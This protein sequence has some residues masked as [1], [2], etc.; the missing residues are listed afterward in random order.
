MSNWTDAARVTGFIKPAERGDWKIEAFDIT[1]ND[2]IGNLGS[3]YATGRGS[4]A[5]GKYTKLTHKGRLWMSDTSD[6]IRDL[7]PL[8]MNATGRVLI[9]GLGLGCAVRLALADPDVTHVDVVEIEPAVIEMVGPYFTGPRCTIHQGDAYTYGWPKG[10]VWDAVWHDIWLDLCGD[11]LPEYT[12]LKR[13]F[14]RRCG[15]QGCWGETFIR[16]R[17]YA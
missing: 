13:K 3:M 1:R 8:Y 6:E 14:G 16:R 17:C 10:A 7:C 4:T 9:H 15:W 5:P 12:R 2:L 11:N